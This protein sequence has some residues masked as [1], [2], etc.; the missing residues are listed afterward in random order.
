MKV[1][2]IGAG[3]LATH[4]SIA[5]QKSGFQ[6]VQ[7]Y[8]RSESSAKELSGLL[9]VPCTTQPCHIVDDA[10]LYIIS[11]SDD[12]IESVSK[13]I[14]ST[15]GLVVHT[16]ACVSMDIFSEKFEN[17]GV[18]YPLQTFS[19]GYPVDFSDL[20]IFLEA[21]TQENLHILL[22]VAKSISQNVFHASLEEREQLHLA[23]IFCCNF[24]NHLYHLS[25]K[26]AQR[27]GFDFK[28]LSSLIFSVSDMTMSPCSLDIKA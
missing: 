20:P 5:L 18:F 22:N 15:H 13:S 12:A 26:I 11:V 14:R 7:I 28:V 27:A 23:A 4:L 17:F 8:N 16:A 6:I 3:N 10:S 19:K 1:V 25:G 21:N 9:Q 24:V 2:I